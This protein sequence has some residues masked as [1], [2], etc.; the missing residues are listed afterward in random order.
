M[1]PT[2]HRT[3]KTAPLSGSRVGRILQL[4]DNPADVGPGGAL[5]G[6]R[7]LSGDAFDDRQVLL[8]LHGA[9]IRAEFHPGLEDLDS[10]PAHPPF[11]SGIGL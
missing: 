4:V 10:Q 5:G 9:V 11:N 3:W 7:V 6:R 2:V 8:R 1:N